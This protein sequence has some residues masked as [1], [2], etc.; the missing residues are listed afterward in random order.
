MITHNGP[1]VIEFNAR[2]GDPE[3][4]VT[5]PR[6]KTDLIDIVL[7]VINGNLDQ[8]D[9]EWSEDACVGVVMVSGGY[10]GSY[11]TGFPIT[12]LDNLDKDILVFHA[13]TKVG[14]EP[15]Q[16]LTSGGRVLTVVAMANT[17]AEAREKIYANISRIHFEGCYYRK[18]IAEIKG[19]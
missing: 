6:L 16:V 10:P 15:G 5:L 14:P 9:V 19:I 7:A 4:Q 1:K 12:G 17:L 18:D 8:I 13:G 2:F 11:K 3:A